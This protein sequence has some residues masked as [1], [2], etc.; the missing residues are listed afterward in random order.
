MIRFLLAFIN[1]SSVQADFTCS[2]I[3]CDCISYF[4]QNTHTDPDGIHLFN[5]VIILPGKFYAHLGGEH[6]RRIINS[7]HNQIVSRVKRFLCLDSNH[8]PDIFIQFRISHIEPNII[9]H[10]LLIWNAVLRADPPH[11]IWKQKLHFF[12]ADSYMHFKTIKIAPPF[13]KTVLFPLND[14]ISIS[15]IFQQTDF[16]TNHF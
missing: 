4:L 6:P 2:F 1:F 13:Q 11:I 12:L 7:S 10:G 8:N 3:I 5:L 16:S 14:P 15:C 9:E